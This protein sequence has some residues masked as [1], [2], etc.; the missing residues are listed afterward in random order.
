MGH[1]APVHKFDMDLLIGNIQTQPI[2]AGIEHTNLARCVERQLARHSVDALQNPAM[3][4]HGNFADLVQC[5]MLA[6]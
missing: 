3:S 2:D 6:T 4:Y 5:I 1:V